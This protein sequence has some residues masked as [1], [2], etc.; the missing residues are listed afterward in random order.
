MA[1]G[2]AADK[3]LALFPLRVGGRYMALSRFDRNPSRWSTPTERGLQRCTPRPAAG[4]CCMSATA[5]H[6]SRR[7]RAGWS[8]PTASGRCP[9]TAWDALLLDVD[10][11]SVVVAAL[12]EPLLTPNT[13]ERDGY[14]ANVVYSCGAL[15]HD[16]IPTIPH[17]ISDSAI[18]IAQAHLPEL[19]DRML[20]RRPSGPPV[21]SRLRP[22][23][24]PRHRGGATLPSTIGTERSRSS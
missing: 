1:G 20:T 2:A 18:G 9:R 23:S 16:D 4:S 21:R 11:P 17:G 7:P 19:L 6:R 24:Y 13:D 3:G 8:S 10:A 12:P 5:V 22:D 14:V 15:L